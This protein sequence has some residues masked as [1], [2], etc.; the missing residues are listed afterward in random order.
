LRGD[1]QGP[2]SVPLNLLDKTL[3]PFLG[4]GTLNWY[5]LWIAPCVGVFWILPVYLISVVT[6]EL[7]ENSELNREIV[8]LRNELDQ[9][10]TESVPERSV[11][12]APQMEG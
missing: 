5:A 12:A 10:S 3:A 9:L 2:F 11:E 8:R 4:Q 6:S 1:Y 7:G